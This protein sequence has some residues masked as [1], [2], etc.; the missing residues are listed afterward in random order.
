MNNKFTSRKFWLSVAS[1]LL[2]TLL[3]SFDK[4]PSNVFENLFGIIV[5]G[6]LISNQTQKYI[7]GSKTSKE[8][9]DAS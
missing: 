5:S 6:Y 1:I 4:L 3:L 7:E 8:K 9:T 2:L